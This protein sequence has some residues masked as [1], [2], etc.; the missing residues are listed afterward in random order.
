LGQLGMFSLRV[1][2]VV[3]CLSL[4]WRQSFCSLTPEA[5]DKE[6]GRWEMGRREDLTKELAP[7]ERE[8]KLVDEAVERLEEVLEERLLKLD[9]DKAEQDEANLVLEERG[10][11]MAASKVSAG[12]RNV[13][14][15]LHR[16]ERNLLK[17]K[18]RVMKNIVWDDQLAR[19]SQG[20]ANQCTWGHANKI[21]PDG[22]LVGQNLAMST[23]LDAAM[24]G[25]VQMWI[26]EKK[27]YNIQTGACGKVCGHYTQIIWSTT[28]KVGC[29]VNQCPGLGKILVC[30]Y[31]PA[32]NWKGQKPV[33][34]KSQPPPCFD[35][36]SNCAT[37]T[38][39]CNQPNIKNGCKKACGRC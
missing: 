23:D 11:Q 6:G 31:L 17:P 7:E 16:G 24:N 10:A 13:I 38:L 30:D 20:L 14:M 3:F 37:L 34:L 22:T 29:G 33:S 28:T 9:S 39:F 1:L 12:D 15:G 4:S 36:Y 25:L 2:G 27:D 35:K 32:G 5:M 26:D 8:D 21:L 18:V 19:L